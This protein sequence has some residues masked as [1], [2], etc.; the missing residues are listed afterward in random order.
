MLPKMAL[1]HLGSDL[2]ASYV[3]CANSVAQDIMPEGSTLLLGDL[4]LEMFT[5]LRMNAD[6][7]SYFEEEHPCELAEL[8]RDLDLSQDLRELLIDEDWITIVEA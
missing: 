4:P 7:I 6:S 2:A 3:E 5:V 8:I 1:A